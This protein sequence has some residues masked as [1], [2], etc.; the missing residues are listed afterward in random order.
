MAADRLVHEGLGLHRLFGLVVAAPPVADQI[1]HHVLLELHP[2]VDG[3]LHREDARLRVVA[4]DVQDRG[5]DHLRDLGAVLRGAGIVRPVG[6]EADLVVDD[7]VNRAAHPVAPGLGHLQRLHH[8]AL[9]GE[10]R[11]AVDADR[12][13]Q[14][15]RVVPATVLAR[16]HGTR[17]HRADDLQMRRVERQRHV[18]LAARRHDVRREALVVLHVAGAVGVG[19]HAVELVE[20][21]ARVLAEDVHQHVQPPPVG[22]AD[23]RLDAAV[24]A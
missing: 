3:Q 8:H 9:A 19:D 23:H 10:R 1:D 5:L 11:I 15:A 13:H 4:V 16:P 7:D 24:R 17:D 21:I 18:H 2:V 6:R 22:H 20:E 12:H 14:I